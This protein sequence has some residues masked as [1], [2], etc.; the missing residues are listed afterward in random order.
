MSSWRRRCERFRSAPESVTQTSEVWRPVRAGRIARHGGQAAPMSCRCAVASTRVAMS[1]RRMLVQA[2]AIRPDPIAHAAERLRHGNASGSSRSSDDAARLPSG[3]CTAPLATS[4]PAARAEREQANYL[5]NVLRLKAGDAILLFNGRDGEWRARIAEAGRKGCR[6]VVE[7]QTR[8][9]TPLPDLHYLF[10]PLKHARLDYMV[11]K[12]VEMG[13]GRLRPVLTQLHAGRAASI[14]SACGERHRG[15]RAMRHPRDP[16]DR[17]AA[18]ARR[19]ARRLG[20]RRAASSSATRPRRSRIRPRR[21]TSLPR[22]PAALADRAGRRLLRPT[23][24][25]IS[26]RRPYVTP[27]SLGPRILRADTAAVAALALVQA[28]IGDWR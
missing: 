14:S 26:S 24:A 3:A 25:P 20:R 8:A 21:S 27:L 18:E 17:R 23:S 5:L 4:S 19:R 15:G 7:E 12:A 1:D 10:A 2:R 13:A 6:L 28:F 11:Q 16:R 22:G 9:Q